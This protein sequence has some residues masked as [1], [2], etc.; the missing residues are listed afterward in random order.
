MSSAETETPPKS[1]PGRTKGEVKVWLTAMGLATGLI[2]IIGLL[3]LIAWNGISVFWPK[4]VHEFT[5]AEADGKTSIIA[6]ELVKTQMRR[7]TDGSGE[8]EEIQ[9]FVGNKDSYGLGFRFLDAES[10]K[11]RAEPTGL[12]VAERMEYGDA[13]FYPVTLELAGGKTIPAED[14]SFETELR[15]LIA[16]VNDR[17]DEILHVEKTEIGAIN[18]RI[19]QFE[20]TIR[21]L[22]RDEDIVPTDRDAKIQAVRDKI[23]AEQGDY[24]QLAAKAK[25]L[26]DKQKEHQ[27]KYRLASGEE[28][29]QPIGDFVYFYQPNQLGV[30]GKLGVFCHQFWEF[31]S[32]EPREAN[33]EGGIFPAIFGTFVMTILMAVMVSPL[34]VIAA[35]YLREYAKQ[36]LMVQI[37]RICVN[38]LAGVPSIVFGVFGLGFFVYGVGGFIDGGP[39]HPLPPFSW[40]LWAMTFICSAPIAIFLAMNYGGPSANLS[41]PH[42][43]IVF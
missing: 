12:I 43:V 30:F 13:I 23:A 38:N 21:G 6:G 10:I 4:V 5:I 2:M 25:A 17:R 37:V 14:A 16:E 35:I 11:G 32:A 28:K 27:L 26:R 3:A 29:S 40:M 34:G 20:L 9:I 39:K 18:E 19:R 42:P 36:G 41:K 24:E 31:V 15:R 8:K 22:E 1:R 33:T 7:S